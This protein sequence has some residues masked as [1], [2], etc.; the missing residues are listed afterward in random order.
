MGNSGH[1][2]LWGLELGTGRGCPEDS[3]A[4]VALEQDSLQG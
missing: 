4:E 1:V 2:T 3:L